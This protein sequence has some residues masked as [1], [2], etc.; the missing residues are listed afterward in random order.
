M[1]NF[2]TGLRG[3]DTSGPKTIPISYWAKRR[4][5]S[6]YISWYFGQKVQLDVSVAEIE[7][8]GLAAMLE[9][10][11]P[12]CYFLYYLLDAYSSENLVQTPHDYSMH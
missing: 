11:V 3:G 9:S 1:M 8:H 6:Q 10:N 2:I 5:Y 4:A 7:K 12:L